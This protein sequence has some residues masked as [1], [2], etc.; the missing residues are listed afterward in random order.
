MDKK[1]LL[2]VFPVVFTANIFLLDFNTTII[3]I[4]SISDEFDL[5]LRLASWIILSASIIMT[6]FLMPIGRI[7]DLVSRKLFYIIALIISLSG[8]ISASYASDVYILIL[9]K[10][11]SAVGTTGTS[12]MMFVIVTATF[13]KKYQGMGLSIITTSVALGM[14]IT[15]F[16]GGVLL[17]NYGWRFAFR[18]IGFLGI[19]TVLMALLFV[20]KME[21][22]EIDRNSMDIIGM[23]YFILIMTLFVFI[24]NDPLS[25]GF[26]SIIHILQIIIFL[27]LVMFFYK[28]ENNHPKPVL[29]F[30]NYKKPAYFWGSISSCLLYTSPSPRDRG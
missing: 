12:I 24:I 25:F 11:I 16:I 7:A 2:V 10:T 13:P 18:L 30:K 9:C 1:L 4:P 21:K 26:F 17:D 29:D 27:V 20:P 6:A 14:M 28:H 15:P 19:F 23:I 5:S 22:P 3:A 8:I